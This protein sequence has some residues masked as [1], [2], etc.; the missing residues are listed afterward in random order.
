MFSITLKDVAARAE[1]S[2]STASRALA[3][4][5]LITPETS[6]K[7]IQAARELGY[8]PN[9]QAR[10]L[11]NAKS[12]AIGLVVPSLDNPFFAHIAAAIETAANAQGIATIISSSAE[13]P[14][15][16]IAS[17]ETLEQRQMDGIIAVPLHGCET[18][19]HRI[20]KE[21]PLILVDRELDN[22]PAV[23][24]DPLPGIAAAVAQLREKG[25]R[26]IG[27]LSG[28]QETSTGRARQEAFIQQTS[29][30]KVSV[31]QGGFE[32]QNGYEG[33]LNLL[34]K[35]VTAIIAG[36]SMMTSGALAACHEAGVKVG[37]Q[38]ALVGFDD[39][40]FLRIQPTPV[41]VIDQDVQTLGSQA[42]LR[43]IKAINTKTTPIGLRHPTRYLARS[44]TDFP[45]TTPTSQATQPGQAN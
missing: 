12:N 16:L 45:P 33:M 19:L 9:V 39:N 42:A 22:L 37:E 24:S 18:T 43:L 30:L 14:Q 44:S 20:A 13:N 1:V 2:V 15:R 8:R 11:R 41:S 25:H 29:N 34:T 17:L 7:V 38:L 4:S 35:G 28:P 3:G 6:K 5:S 21:R 31:Y 23:V 27:Y 36:D 10:A 26:H 40:V 32:Y